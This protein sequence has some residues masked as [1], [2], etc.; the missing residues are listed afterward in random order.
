MRNPVPELAVGRNSILFLCRAVPE[1]VKAARPV[2]KPADRDCR[3]LRTFF[4][5]ELSLQT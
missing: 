5:T 2:T 4:I 3:E 1:T